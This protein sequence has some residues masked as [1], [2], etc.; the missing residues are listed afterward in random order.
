MA[1]F[2]K[3]VGVGTHWHDN[4]PRTTGGFLA[5]SPGGPAGTDTVIYHI[6]KGTTTTPYISLTRSY[7]VAED[8]ARQASRIKPT[9]TRPSYV[10]EIEIG[11]SPPAGLRV[12]DPIKVLSQVIDPL[13]TIAYYH[14]GDTK[15]LL[16]VVDSSTMVHH[17]T[18]PMRAPANTATTPRPAN[19]QPS[20]E[21]MV[22]ALRDAEVLALGA[23]PAACIV[24]RH[25][26]L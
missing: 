25:E 26:V 2:F 18:A 14:D 12:E 3:G 1:R 13:A 15:F 10:F 19:L 23:I 7:G 20:L 22:R 16:G 4:D 17:L 21:A 5:R 8:Y 11:H 6:A 24:C 9:R